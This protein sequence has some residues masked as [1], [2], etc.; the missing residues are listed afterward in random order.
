MPAPEL[1]VVCKNCGNEVSQ[2]VTECPY[3]GTRLRKR[4][5]KLDKRPAAR[6]TEAAPR[7]PR[8]GRLR[9]DEIPGIRPDRRP[10]VT[11]AL[12]VLSVV[13]TLVWRTGLVG[14]ADVAVV[15]GVGFDMDPWQPFTAPFV[16]DNTGYLLICLV[17][18]ALFGWLFERRHGPVVTALVFAAGACGGL[19]AAGTIDTD[20]VAL[21]ANG[22]ALA[23]VGAWGIPHLLARRHGR[24]EDSD[25]L[26][27]AA[28]VAVVAVVPAATA[29]ASA[30]AGAVG[31]LVGLAAGGLSAR[32]QPVD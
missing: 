25:L 24:A 20:V 30:I 27:T 12:L 7:R 1:F 23:L 4:A 19:A 14:L 22:G 13:G 6:P 3:C 32:A 15:E 21:G 9:R 10:Y 5:P 2:Y 26:G 31:V 18:I 29:G 8:L 17:P 16:Y 11:L 28:I